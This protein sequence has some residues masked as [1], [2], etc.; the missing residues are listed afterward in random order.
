M[1]IRILAAGAALLIP[2]GP[3]GAQTLTLAEART[4]PVPV[5]AQ[6]LLGAAGSLYGE[7]ERPGPYAGLSL[8][9]GP[10]RGL[11][12]L[13]FAGTPRSAGFAGI[14]N[15]E[16]VSLAFAAIRPPSATDADPPARVTGLWT[17]QQYSIV[18]DTENGRDGRRLEESCARAGPVFAERDQQRFFSGSAFGT[19]Q[20]SAAQVSFAAHAFQQA[21]RL[22]A[23]GT[24][25]PACT[26]A[27]SFSPE[28]LCADP[29]RRLSQ[30]LPANISGIELD[31]CA[32]AMARICVSVSFTMPGATE[33]A[34]RILTVRIETD[35]AAA[36]P[37]PLQL[38]VRQVT[39]SGQMLVV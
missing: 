16:I 13:S 6:R 10:A 29:S 3:A 20:M 34:A 2:A 18:G 7:V 30:L 27:R 37:R 24:I 14:C 4:L 26:P 9:G 1:T 32:D 28:E 23:A 12:F 38:E 11:T 22:A 17:R 39:L 36:D 33:W 19:Y 21:K 5:L 25:R 15:A 31:R 35:A 8:P